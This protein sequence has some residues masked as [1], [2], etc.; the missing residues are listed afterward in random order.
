VSSQKN[1]G[2]RVAS[3][4]HSLCIAFALQSAPMS[5]GSDTSFVAAFITQGVGFGTGYSRLE[6][7]DAKN[8]AGT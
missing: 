4:Q 5:K 1:T 7:K 2:F 8:K 6:V 3:E